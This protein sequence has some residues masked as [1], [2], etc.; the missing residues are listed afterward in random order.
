ML[1]A[2]FLPPD[3]EQTLFQQYQNCRQGSRTVAAYTE[4][5]QRLQ[6][7]NELS[8]TEAQQVA[9][10]IR[11][12]RVAIQDRVSLQAIFSITE[13]INSATRAEAQLDRTHTRN[14]LPNRGSLDSSRTALNKEKQPVT[15]L[16]P[17]A[18]N[19]EVSNSS[20]PTENTTRNPNPYEKPIIDKCYRCG[21]SGHH[22]N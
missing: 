22:S 10:F 11:G 6:A 1:R 14:Q 15:S 9:R 3:Y 21:V 20:G 19:R 13:A 7:R 12:L 4:E 8:E 5:F 17:I 2:R 16:P 18:T